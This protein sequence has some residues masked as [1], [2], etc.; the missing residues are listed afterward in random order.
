[1]LPLPYE[2]IGVD[3]GTC[4][5]CIGDAVVGSACGCEDEVAAEEEFDVDIDEYGGGGGD[6]AD[7]WPPCIADEGP[8]IVVE[9]ED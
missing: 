7:E 9:E 8:C 3:C 1:M 6:I 5:S 4:C 2:Y